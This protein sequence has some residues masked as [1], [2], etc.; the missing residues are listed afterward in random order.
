MTEPIKA[1]GDCSLCNGKGEVHY[2]PGQPQG[3]YPVGSRMDLPTMT[4]PTCLAHWRGVDEAVKKITDIIG[5]DG[6]LF[7]ARP[8]ST[9]WPPGNRNSWKDAS[10]R[11]LTCS[12]CREVSKIIGKPFGCEAYI[13]PPTNKG[14]GK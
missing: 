6:H 4:C 7:G 13:L 8:C 5:I 10:G 1:W 2:D 11:S 14:E 12:T 9:S 3:L